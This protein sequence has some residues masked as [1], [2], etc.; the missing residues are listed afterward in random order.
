MSYPIDSLKSFD[1]P[2]QYDVTTEVTRRRHFFPLL[3]YFTTYYA[4]TEGL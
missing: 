2:C 4:I 3:L 1:S